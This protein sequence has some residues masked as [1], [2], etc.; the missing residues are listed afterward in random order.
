MG[1][2]DPMAIGNVAATGVLV[3]S[4]GPALWLMTV[5]LLSTMA[6]AMALSGLNPRRI[7]RRWSPKLAHARLTAVGMSGAK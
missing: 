6:V 3:F 7:G 4:V 2:I 1:I 5:G